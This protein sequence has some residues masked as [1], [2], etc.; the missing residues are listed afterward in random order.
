MTKLVYYEENSNLY[1]ISITEV[2]LN[3]ALEPKSYAINST[4][5]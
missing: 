2:K 3:K 4:I 5:T 1:L